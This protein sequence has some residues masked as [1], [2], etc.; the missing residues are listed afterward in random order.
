M[1]KVKILFAAAAMTLGI[2]GAF[3]FTSFADC[4]ALVGYYEE[5]TSPAEE[6]QF[7]IPGNLGTA[8]TCNTAISE[9]CR[10]VKKVDGS[11]VQCPGRLEDLP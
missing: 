8:Y 10:W 5:P 7:R 6:T 9:Q 2:G 3:A 11:F 1:K 4:D